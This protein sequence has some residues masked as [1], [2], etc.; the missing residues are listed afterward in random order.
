MALSLV[1]L[2]VLTPF[3][4]GSYQ[5]GTPGAPWTEEQAEIIR[6][7]TIYFIHLL[8]IRKYFDICQRKTLHHG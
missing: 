7:V 4:L 1:L 5:P 2:F 6:Y 3:A 8:M